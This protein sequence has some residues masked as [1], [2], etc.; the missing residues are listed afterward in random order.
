MLSARAS[1]IS[2][3]G[4]HSCTVYKAIISRVKVVKQQKNVQFIGQKQSCSKKVLIHLKKLLICPKK[5]LICPKNYLST[6]ND[7]NYDWII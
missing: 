1:L 3:Q 6:Q 2:V 7:Y 4:K 5:L